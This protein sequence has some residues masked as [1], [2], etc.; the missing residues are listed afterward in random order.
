MVT[1]NGDFFDWPFVEA[2]AEF[3]GLKM[4]DE[5]GFYKDSQDEYKH[6]NSIHM[7]AFR[8]VQHDSYLPVG[9]QNLK[10]ATKAKLRYDPI[11]LDPELMVQMAKYQPQTLASYSVSDAVS[12]YYL[13]MK[14][15]HP[16]IFALRTIIPF[17][18]DDV[19]RK[20]SEFEAFHAGIIFPNKQI[21]E[22]HKMTKDEHLLESETY[23][24][25]H[26]EALESGVF[27]ADIP[28]KFRME[29]EALE[30]LESEVKETLKYS[31]EHEMG[32]DL[33]TLKDL[34]E[35]V[36]KNSKQFG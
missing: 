23:V 35:V 15:V 1:Y 30:K 16:F 24:G 9:N 36:Q 33:E 19:L 6:I 4:Y 13:Y 31:L 22:V 17:G 20:G 32:M 11:E 28:C 21:S 8:C 12:T 26:V 7:D 5:I 2:R 18:P 34:D 14:Y 27:R 3:H 25:E 10:A 29:I